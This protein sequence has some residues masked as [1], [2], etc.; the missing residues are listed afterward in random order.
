ML[1][2]QPQPSRTQ[3]LTVPWGQHHCPSCPTYKSRVRGG[4]ALGLPSLSSDLAGVQLHPPQTQGPTSAA[5]PI[6]SLSRP[7]SEW[8]PAFPCTSWLP[9]Q[10]SQGPRSLSGISTGTNREGGLQPFTVPI[11][12]SAHS[13]EGGPGIFS[14]PSPVAEG[15]RMFKA[16]LWLWGLL[17]RT[18]VIP[19][20]CPQPATVASRR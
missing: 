10:Q 2:G 14:S 9:C 11:L 15:R 1:H 12:A 16:S 19:P 4:G 6:R 20:P 5:L 3:C 17:C 7:A 18:H 13:L 8:D